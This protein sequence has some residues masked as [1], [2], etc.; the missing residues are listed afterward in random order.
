M[1]TDT[2]CKNASCPLGRKRARL[3]DSGRLYLETSP[4]GSKRWF[5]KLY[6]NGKETRMALGSYPAVSL[7]E[8]RLARDDAKREKASGVN[9]IQSRKV[10]KLKPHPRYRYL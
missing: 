3:T 8:A 2:D 7:K 10:E 6:S 9:P 1:L 5:M 4:G